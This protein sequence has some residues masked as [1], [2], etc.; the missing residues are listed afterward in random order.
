MR[1]GGSAGGPQ[2]LGYVG[3]AAFQF[4]LAELSEVGQQV[5]LL[6]LGEELGGRGAIQVHDSL[7][8]LAFGHDRT[9]VGLPWSGEGDLFG[10]AAWR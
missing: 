5:V 7:D 10:S 4:D 6:E 3:A 9:S 2:G 8:D 1:G